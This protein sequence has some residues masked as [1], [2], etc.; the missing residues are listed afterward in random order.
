[1]QESNEGKINVDNT[2]H[3]TYLKRPPSVLST[4]LSL[5]RRCPRLIPEQQSPG[6]IK[7]CVIHHV[8]PATPKH[9]RSHR[10][11]ACRCD[12]RCEDVMV[13]PLPQAKPNVGRNHMNKS[14]LAFWVR[15]SGRAR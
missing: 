2:M 13:G 6:S 10:F 12:G 7:P 8:A 15:I 5:G 14:G 9:T 1:M 3:M 4:Y 11:T